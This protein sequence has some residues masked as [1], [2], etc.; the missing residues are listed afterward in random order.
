MASG[1]GQPPTS[2]IAEQQNRDLGFGSVLSR[3][4]QLRLLNRDGSFNV[5]RQRPKWWRRLT[6]YH[7]LLNMTWPTFFAFVFGAF[8]AINALFAV[9]YYLSGPNSVQGEVGV[10]NQ[11]LRCFFFSVDTFATIGY[12]NLAPAGVRAHVIVSI[13][14]LVGLMAFAIATGLVF[15]KF[16]RPVPNIVY[17]KN[18]I[19]APY[20]GITAFE[21]RIINGS[22]NQ[23]ID[24]Q[25]RV[26]LT[27]FEDREGSPQRKYHPL[28]LERDT[29]SF[30]PAAWTVVHPIDNSSPLY[31]WTREELVASRAEFLILLTATDETFSQTVQSRSSYVAEEVL[32]GVR[33]ANLFQDRDRLIT[34][35]MHRFHAVEPADLNTIG[36]S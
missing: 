18:A 33:F 13:E 31:G 6:S 36:R 1:S 16:A 24:V 8:F 27:R 3:Q 4:R 10:D 29:V 20:R 34:I 5:F 19:I 7:F 30:F 23:L 14:A 35:D 17:S 32:W 12:G 21:F 26:V 2:D 15:A 11:F 9:V 25:A 28:N 22:D